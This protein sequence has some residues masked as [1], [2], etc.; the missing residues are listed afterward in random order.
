MSVTIVPYR[1]EWPAEFYAI[2]R[3]LRIALGNSA[4]RIDHIGST[5]VPGLAAKDRIDVQVSVAELSSVDA[6]G[7]RLEALGYEARPNS[8]RDHVPANMIENSGDWEKRFFTSGARNRPTNI[9]VRRLGAANQRY[10]LLFRDYLR[11]HPTSAA[12]YGELKRR[13]T[14]QLSDLLT[15]TEVKDPACDLIMIAAEDWARWQGWTPGPTDC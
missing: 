7:P 2:A 6:V 13:I 1:A 12:A 4:L 14:A 9:H 3:A 5:A 11:A 10:A 8:A 15:Y